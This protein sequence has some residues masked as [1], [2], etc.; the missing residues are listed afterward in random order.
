MTRMITQGELKLRDRGQRDA[1]TH[2]GE[3]EMRTL[4][5]WALELADLREAN[6]DG[7]TAGDL[8]ASLPSWVRARVDQSP[9]AMGCLFQMLARRG[10]IEPHPERAPRVA[11]HEGSRGRKQMVWRKKVGAV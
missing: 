2:L 4:E 1:E 9:N 5:R 8:R 10:A 6:G 7:F 11:T 3:E